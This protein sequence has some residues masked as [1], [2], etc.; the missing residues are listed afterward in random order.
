MR[1]R[2]LGNRV[3]VTGD[4]SGYRP[5]RKDTMSIVDVSDIMDAA[6]EAAE[7]VMRTQ[8]AD[9]LVEV[10]G[11]IAEALEGDYAYDAGPEEYAGEQIDDDGDTIIPEDH[12]AAHT[13]LVDAWSAGWEACRAEL[14]NRIDTALYTGFRPKDVDA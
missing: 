5:S 8:V 11:G 9:G 14:I 13:A 6:L 3:P 1:G 4:G 12:A 7:R 10:L 2:H